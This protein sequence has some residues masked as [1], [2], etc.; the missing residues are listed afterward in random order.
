MAGE[1]PND[2]GAPLQADDRLESWGEI[3]SFL[4]RSVS[5]AQR[6]EKKERLPVR[7]HAH[8]KSDSVYAYKH[9]ID[10]WRRARSSSPDRE[11]G[12]ARTTVR[13]RAGAS[14]PENFTVTPAARNPPAPTPDDIGGPQL[15]AANTINPPGE[16]H[17]SSNGPTLDPE[18]QSL[19][20]Q[21]GRRRI[22]LAL[23]VAVL[24]SVV[25]ISRFLIGHSGLVW[26]FSGE[27]KR[28]GNPS[29]FR[30]GGCPK[31][32]SSPP[33]VDLYHWDFYRYL[34][35]AT[36]RPT[37]EMTDPDLGACYQNPRGYCLQWTTWI[38]HLMAND[39]YQAGLVD[40]NEIE[41]RK[42][43]EKAYAFAVKAL[44]YHAPEGGQGFDQCISTEG[45]IEIL[46]D[47]LHRTPAR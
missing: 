29:L 37:L 39:F 24:L 47:K 18:R 23:G 2:G 5:T 46:R 3:A 8:E 1:V 19:D 17:W 14:A 6:W 44:Q 32:W 33:N 22:G 13:V 36:R 43:F 25:V 31:Q 7:R 21:R 40:R 26:Y 41:Q 42:K 16:Q 10:A 15:E 20:R 9:E 30:I 35:G 11:P 4:D 27:I 34:E 45:L 28:L 12:L 38:Y